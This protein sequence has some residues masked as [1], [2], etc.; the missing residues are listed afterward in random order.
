MSGMPVRRANSVGSCSLLS[1]KSSLSSEYNLSIPAKERSRFERRLSVVIAGRGLRD[2]DERLSIIQL[3][4]FSARRSVRLASASGISENKLPDR[5][6][7]WSVLAT[8]A[9][10][11]TDNEVRPFSA[12]LRCLRKRHLDEGS[13]PMA[14][15]SEA[16]CLGVISCWLDPELPEDLRYLGVRLGYDFCREPCRDVVGLGGELLGCLAAASTFFP[17]EDPPLAK[18]CGLPTELR[19]SSA[20]GELGDD[21]ERVKSMCL[22]LG[23]PA[24]HG[25]PGVDGV[26]GTWVFE[27]RLRFRP[28]ASSRTMFRSKSAGS[29]T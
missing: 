25:T 10:L 4:R 23:L 26:V 11:L 17:S 14:S 16:L 18:V 19:R 3:L 20:N 6:R 13:I 22:A 27:D 1:R 5:S 21:T 15:K 24:D 7:D 28:S 2:N 12:R 9:K 29:S 8:G